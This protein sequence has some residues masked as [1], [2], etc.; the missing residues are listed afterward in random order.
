[1]DIDKI[2]FGY[3]TRAPYASDPNK[4]ARRLIVEKESLTRTPFQ[5]DRDRIIHSN[6][7]RRLKHKTQ[8]FIAHEGDHYRTRLTHT[9]EV[10]QIARAIARALK[11]DEDLA[12]AIALVHDFGHTPFG[13]AGE[14]ALNAMMKPYGGF[15]HNVQG[16]RIVTKLENRYP[17]FDGLNLT[18][19]TLEGLVKHNGPLIGKYTHH[20]T[21]HDDIKIFNA[22]FDL[23]LDTFAS[24]EAQCAAIADDIAY[25]AH[26][27][28]DGLRAHLLTLHQLEDVPILS[29][30]LNEIHSDHPT[31]DDTKIG[32]ELVRRL[33]TLMVEDVITQALK[34]ITKYN[35][36]NITD[37]YRATEPTVVFSKGLSKK[38]KILKKFLF[39]N[40]YFHQKV[41]S[42]RIKA[43]NIVTSLFQYFM[44][45]PSA[46]SEEWHEKA[47]VAQEIDLARI[48]SDFLSGMT[49]NFAL[50]HYQRLFHQASNLA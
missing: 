4:N 47:M 30:I 34:N 10:S 19:A 25:N 45:D 11:L 12:E 9:I 15:D 27:I 43:E 40:L 37:V 26:D 44:K 17:M 39:D 50:R 22:N 3:T 24:L 20:S 1:M 18:W 29:D 28:D 36:I 41:Q 31:L 6:A 14:D 2:G 13:H 7:F 42:D 46:M 38:E 48:I 35:F 5:R 33:I 32:Y 8:V 16:L 23:H 21:L 49:D